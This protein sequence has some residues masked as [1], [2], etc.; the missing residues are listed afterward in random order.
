MN[1]RIVKIDRKKLYEEVWEIPTS[2]LAKKYGISDVALSKVCKKLNIPKPPRGYWARKNVGQQVRRQQLAKLRTGQPFE[3]RLE[4]RSGSPNLNE[5]NADDLSPESKKIISKAKTLVPIHVSKALRDPHPLVQQAAEVLELSR[6]DDAGIIKPSSKNCL[7]I[8]V[9]KDSLRRSLR[10][11]DALIKAL[12]NLDFEVFL[13]DGSTRISI[14]NTELSFGISEETMMKKVEPK[15]VDLNGYYRFGHSRYDQK[16][17]PSGKLCLTVHSV[18]YFWGDNMRQ[19]WRDTKHKRLEENLESFVKGLIKFAIQKNEHQRRKEETERKKLEMLKKR[20]EE[21]RRREE[22]ERR[23]KHE[24]QKISQLIEDAENWD[25]SKLIREFVATVE[26]EHFS[27]NQAY[28]VQ[29]DFDL[30]LKWTKEQADRLD[31][32]T[33]SSPSI[34]NENSDLSDD[35]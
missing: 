20:E 32:L 15:D 5:E 12:L 10:I 27:G 3:H 7:N 13:P 21:A 22:L 4:L 25:K 19:N 1:N 31:P 18:R 34:L 24:Q 17:V 2:Q 9:S 33:P 6:P 28:E 11:M 26:R 14:F 16:R 30:W 29:G 8:C 35:K 23:I